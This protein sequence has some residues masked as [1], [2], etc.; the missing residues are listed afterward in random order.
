MPDKRIQGATIAR[1]RLV[2]PTA[3]LPTKL[4]PGSP[5]LEVMTDLADEA[6]HV[7]APD[8]QI[9]AALDDM[10]RYSVRLLLVA[11]D[12]EVVGMVT[13]YDIMGERPI[14]FLQGTFGTDPTLRHSDIKVADIMTPLAETQPLRFDWVRLATVGDVAALFH[15]NGA[16]HLLVLDED[17]TQHHYAVRGIF[18]RSRL[19]RQFGPLA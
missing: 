8:R 18:L 14:Q 5:A 1:A 17:A 10:I 12:T 7:V 16:T 3:P 15:E 19:E 6:P 11:R 2:M 9:D 13:S 4:R